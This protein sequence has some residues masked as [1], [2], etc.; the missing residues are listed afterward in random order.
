MTFR[1][2]AASPRYTV[3]AEWQST[4]RVVGRVRR[5]ADSRESPIAS[6]Y[7]AA[8]LTEAL[9]L[10]SAPALNGA[11]RRVVAT[12]VIPYDILMRSIRRRARRS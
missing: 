7:D 12:Y 8:A 10:N 9:R 3:E 2:Y 11:A 4:P 5:L 1:Y 6:R